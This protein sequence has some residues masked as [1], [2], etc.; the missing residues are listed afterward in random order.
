MTTMLIA[1]AHIKVRATGGGLTLEHCEDGGCT[2][3]AE[4]HSTCGR[5]ACPSCG[6]SGANLIAAEDGEHVCRCGH[7]WVTGW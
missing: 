6:S 5:L 3:D 1:P 7:S 2:V 4:G